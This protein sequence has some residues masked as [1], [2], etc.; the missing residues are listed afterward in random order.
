MLFGAGAP[1]DQ[2]GDRTI[3]H[4]ALASAPRA[5][6]KASFG[7]LCRASLGT[8]NEVSTT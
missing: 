7:D 8:R 4:G 6:E 5:R 3:D 2:L 1:I